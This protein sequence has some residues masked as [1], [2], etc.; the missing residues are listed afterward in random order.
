MGN[1]S[2]SLKLEEEEEA[3]QEVKQEIRLE[4]MRE[5]EQEIRQESKQEVEQ[6]VE[7][8]VMQEVEQ[9]V[10]LE[11]K[12]EVEQEAEQK[13]QQ[14]VQQE[15]KQEAEGNTNSP[16]VP[17]DVFIPAAVTVQ[18]D[19]KPVLNHAVERP[20]SINIESRPHDKHRRRA[21][22]RTTTPLP[23]PISRLLLYPSLYRQRHRPFSRQSCRCLLHR[24][25]R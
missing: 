21:M 13:A 7:Q 24:P 20:S 18:E 17:E 12:Q 9:D 23:G 25:Q 14:D 6:K 3:Q 16:V 11:V 2:S 5:V 19:V 10:E 22:V 15:I 4:V 1:Q 8:E